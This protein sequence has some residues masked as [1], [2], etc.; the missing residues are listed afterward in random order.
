MNLSTKKAYKRNA[1]VYNYK[2]IWESTPFH[3]ILH[4]FKLNFKGIWF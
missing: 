2:Q 3:P 4:I 1:R